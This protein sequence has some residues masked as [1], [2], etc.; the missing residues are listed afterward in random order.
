MLGFLGAVAAGAIFS[1][2]PGALL[3]L[4]M[5]EAPRM[6]DVLGLLGFLSATWT[7]RTLAAETLR[8]F[9]DIRM[10]SIFSR[11]SVSAVTV[12][13]YGCIW[14][15]RGSASLSE[16]LVILLMSSAL[17]CIVAWFVLGQKIVGVE[18][19]EGSLVNPRE[20]PKVLRT[21]LPIFS[22]GLVSLLLSY[23]TL[24]MLGVFAE[25]ADVALY[26][27]A[28][29]VSAAVIIPLMVIYAVV[30]P[31]I[32]QLFAA[33]NQAQLERILRGSAGLALAVGAVGGTVLIV[34]G[35]Q[36]LVL[37]LD[38]FYAQAATALSILTGAQ[39]VNLATGACGIALVQTGHQ[40]VFLRIT[41]V[42]AAFNIVLGMILIPRFELLGAAMSAGISLIA[43]QVACWLSARQCV[44]L[45]THV[46]LAGWEEVLRIVLKPARS[47][48]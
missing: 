6:L 42:V 18:T 21:A 47:H 40:R 19:D 41:L 44:G 14:L 3:V 30:G 46:S 1:L 13:V 35:K 7:L 34:W 4:E 20:A 15:I 26:G 31:L 2:G 23:A 43:L 37:F 36:V 8:S 38:P 24:W 22:S 27:A 25:E 48:R 29:R 11:L 45:W 39:F 28:L 5:F 16:V 32:A 17:S 10:A 33:G 12:L 9:N